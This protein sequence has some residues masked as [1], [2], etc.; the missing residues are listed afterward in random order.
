M[1]FG[2]VFLSRR[3]S[4]RGPLL[5]DQARLALAQSLARERSA[6]RLE[7]KKNWLGA[8]E[9]RSSGG[10]RGIYSK[11]MRLKFIQSQKDPSPL[12]PTAGHL[13]AGSHL[14]V[15]TAA[16]RPLPSFRTPLRSLAHQLSSR[17]LRLAVSPPPTVAA[18]QPATAAD[19]PYHPL[20][21]F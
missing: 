10:G 15:P 6:Q 9:K 4:L 2:C 12:A 8:E 14:P 18:L 19:L 3:F 20:F 13:T 1:E 17:Y 5:S 16:P 11:H 7:G 21:L